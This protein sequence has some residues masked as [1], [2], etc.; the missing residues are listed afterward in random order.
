MCTAGTQVARVSIM[1][2]ACAQAEI[3]WSAREINRAVNAVEA[4]EYMVLSCLS[5][6][7]SLSKIC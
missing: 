5:A 3:L 1:V 7:E 6:H 4:E 2:A